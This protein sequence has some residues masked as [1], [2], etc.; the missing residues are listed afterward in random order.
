MQSTVLD[1]P[2]TLK[3]AGE[4]IQ[5]HNLSA[6]IGT[7]EG[8][9]FSDDIGRDYDLVWISQILHSL[10]ETDCGKLLAR[11][12]E[13]LAPGGRVIV[14]DF[15]INGDRTAPLNAAL[16]A[17]HM[18]AVT[19]EGRVYTAGEIEGWMRKVG[20]AQT[21]VTNINQMVMLVEGIK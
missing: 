2:L 15:W 4:N 8:N 3:V 20:F 14:H 6:R 11:A 12:Y 9:F 19:K 10:S 18:L 16:F 1:L 21:K 5:R 13:A 17:V 7:C